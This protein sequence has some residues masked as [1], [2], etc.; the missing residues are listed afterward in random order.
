MLVS[1]LVPLAFASAAAA[2]AIRRDALP[3][4][5]PGID[6]QLNQSTTLPIILDNSAKLLLGG[7][8]A[9]IVAQTTCVPGD[10]KDRSCGGAS[11]TCFPDPSTAF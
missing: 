10:V 11:H 1:L 9:Y 4:A 3:V 6:G 7:E 2:K 5:V 8:L